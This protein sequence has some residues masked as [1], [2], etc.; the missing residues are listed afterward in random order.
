MAQSL[1]RLIG[2]DVKFMWSKDCEKS[3]S[4]INKMLISAHVLALPG[5]IF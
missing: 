3:F 1:T 4:S 2:K 5:D